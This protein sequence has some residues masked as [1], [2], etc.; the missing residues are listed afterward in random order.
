MSVGIWVKIVLVRKEDLPSEGR[1][2]EQIYALARIFH[3]YFP[4]NT[5]NVCIVVITIKLPL[6][7]PYCNIY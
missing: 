1:V 6:L 4:T 2:I 5:K 7:H 3:I